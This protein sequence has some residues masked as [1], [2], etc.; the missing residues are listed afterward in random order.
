MKKTGRKFKCIR[1]M[2]GYDDKLIFQ[3]TEIYEETI[4]NGEK[5]LISNGFK[6]EIKDS[7]IRFFFTLVSEGKLN[8]KKK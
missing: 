3:K 8:T 5:L 1:D 7:L 4:V 6:V 2:M